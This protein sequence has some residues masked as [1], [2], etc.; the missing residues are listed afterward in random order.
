MIKGEDGSTAQFYTVSIDDLKKR[1]SI[2]DNKDSQILKDAYIKWI[3]DRRNIAPALCMDKISTLLG[4]QREHVG[5]E[6]S[7]TPGLVIENFDKDA[8]T[9]LI[10]SIEKLNDEA[11]ELEDSFEDWFLSDSKNHTI[12]N[13]LGCIDDYLEQSEIVLAEL[14]SG[15][16]LK[17][18]DYDFQEG[19]KQ[20]EKAM[21][22]ANNYGIVSQEDTHS[23]A[24]WF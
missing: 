4:Y 8:Y 11:E 12:E 3:N 20:L 19:L 9:V 14:K 23:K 5:N 24:D 10:Q 21:K 22:Y 17:S 1:P 18:L 6:S 2:L 15:Q 16:P 13:I 7:L